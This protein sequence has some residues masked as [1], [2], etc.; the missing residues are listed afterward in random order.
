MTPKMTPKMAQLVSPVSQKRINKV[1]DI[2]YYISGLFDSKS[3][4]KKV[5][6]RGTKH[7]GGGPFINPRWGLI[8]MNI[9]ITL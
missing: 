5:V 3:I 2:I 9:V 1:L 8:I 6:F 4:V 7:K